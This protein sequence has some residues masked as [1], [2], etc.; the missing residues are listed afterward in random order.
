[1]PLNLLQHMGLLHIRGIKTLSPSFDCFVTH[2]TRLFWSGLIFLSVVFF[3][4][5]VFQEVAANVCLWNDG[6]EISLH[7]HIHVQPVVP[8][9]VLL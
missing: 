5:N 7:F 1:M 9:P 6:L 3:L 8:V 4:V 2:Y